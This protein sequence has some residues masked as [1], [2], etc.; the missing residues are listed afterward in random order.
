VQQA[1]SEALQWYQ[2]VSVVTDLAGR[3]RI[4]IARLRSQF[5][6]DYPSGQG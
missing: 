1:A 2:D 4:V 3:D 5:D 6:P